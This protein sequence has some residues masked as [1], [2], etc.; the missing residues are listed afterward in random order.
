MM[1][2]DL[3]DLEITNCVWLYELGKIFDGSEVENVRDS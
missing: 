2:I 1:R 3:I